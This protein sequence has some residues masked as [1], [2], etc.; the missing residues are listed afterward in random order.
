MQAGVHQDRGALR[1]KHMACVACSYAQWLMQLDGCPRCHFGRAQVTLI[2]VG[3]AV[4]FI[5]IGGVCL[6]YGMSVSAGCQSVKEVEQFC[7]CWLQQFIAR[8][9]TACSAGCTWFP[10][11]VAAGARA[12]VSLR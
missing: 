12:V 5:P 11:C 8:E 1:R 3:V 4:L 9:R 7:D 10:A 2:F 6:A